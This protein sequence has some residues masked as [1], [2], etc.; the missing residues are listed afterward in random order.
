MLRCKRSSAHREDER[1]RSCDVCVGDAFAHVLP[2]QAGLDARTLR[3]QAAVSRGEWTESPLRAPN[4]VWGL[5]ASE[6]P[7]FGG[8]F[9]LA[10][11]TARQRAASGG[12]CC[13][14]A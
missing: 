7:R 2:P 11:G 1:E 13:A 6:S 4:G 9:A 14:V 12:P 10:F 5:P 3:G 8:G